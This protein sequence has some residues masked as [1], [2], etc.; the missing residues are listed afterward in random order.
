MAVY[1]K[2][3]QYTDATSIAVVTTACYLKGVRLWFEADETAQDAWLYLYD[4][5]QA[6]STP[7]TH[8]ADIVLYMPNSSG[9]YKQIWNFSFPR[10]YF[11]TALT[12]FVADTNGD[13][14]SACTSLDRIK[15]YYVPD[16]A[17][18]A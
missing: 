7:A 2:E 16:V 5:G 6:A 3:G 8:I 9:P 10:I 11:A 15:I 13:D 17:A 18:S 14:V 1:S 4:L 12:A